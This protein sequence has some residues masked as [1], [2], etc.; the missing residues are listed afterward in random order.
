M[1][2]IFSQETKGFPNRSVSKESTCIAGDLVQFLG[3]EDPL[4]KE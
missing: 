2:F 4:E 1:A 3:K